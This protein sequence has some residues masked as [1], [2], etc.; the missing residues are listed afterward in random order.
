MNEVNVVENLHHLCDYGC[1]QEAHYQL[2]NGKWCCSTSYNKCPSLRK[3][4]S[5]GLRNAHKDPLKYQNPKICKKGYP[6]WNRGL[7]KDTDIR[8]KKS[9]ET[10]IEGLRTG[11][12][13][14]GWLGRKHSPESKEKIRLA[15]LKAHKEGRAHNI[16]ECRWNNKPS[17]PE[18]FF[19]NVIKNE[20]CDKDYKREMPFHKFSLDFAWVHKKK[21]IEIDGEQHQYGEQP[22]RDKEKDQ[23]L[24]LEG[25]EV[26]RIKWIDMYHETKQYIKIAKEFIDG[27]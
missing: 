24:I 26:L 15:A 18:Q 13:K 6:P 3:K 23:L 20:F 27:V 1:G 12:I 22:R 8:I 10:Y 5:C 2:K 21:C 17:W 4:N 16:G 7:T 14:N 25:W 9:S 19:M 11:R